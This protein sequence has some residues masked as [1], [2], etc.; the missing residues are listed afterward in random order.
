MQ[1]ELTNYQEVFINTLL[2]VIPN[3]TYQLFMKNYEELNEFINNIENT[4]MYS[5]ISN[6]WDQVT[7][8]NGTTKKQDDLRKLFEAINDTSENALNFQHPEC[9]ERSFYHE[10]QWSLNN[11]KNDIKKYEELQTTEQLKILQCSIKNL[12]NKNKTCMINED[13]TTTQQF[14]TQLKKYET[15]VINE[16]YIESIDD[17][18]YEI[19]FLD[20][21]WYMC[22][23]FLY[24]GYEEAKK[25]EKLRYTHYTCLDLLR[26]QGVHLDLADAINK[27]SDQKKEYVYK[28]KNIYKK[29]K[30]IYEE[31]KQSHLRKGR[32]IPD[33]IQDDIQ[34][35]KDNNEDLQEEIENIVNYRSYMSQLYSMIDPNA[36]DKYGDQLK[37]DM[38]KNIVI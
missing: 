30:E 36:P 2:K 25:Y 27:M 6:S 14:I 4:I 18:K 34:E 3:E 5:V 19:E 8:N 23:A 24:G 9:E 15:Y 26:R 20:V 21:D 11:I 31:Y 22:A 7:S 13:T 32:R 38:E 10:N 16:N 28:A 12:N 29:Q 37:E 1:Q 35:L 17:L 33:D